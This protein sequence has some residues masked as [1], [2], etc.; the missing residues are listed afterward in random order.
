[1]TQKYLDK[2]RSLGYTEA[3]AERQWTQ[4]MTRAGE[5]DPIYNAISE[6]YPGDEKA[7]REAYAMHLVEGVEPKAA[8]A[9]INS[10]PLVSDTNS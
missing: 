9:S 10:D 4:A 3:E 2:T 6:M 8:G 7:A 1:M 5:D